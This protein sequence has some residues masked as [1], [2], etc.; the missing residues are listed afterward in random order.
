MDTKSREFSL[1]C[2]IVDFG[3]GSK[4][5]KEAKR[6]GATGGTIFLGKGSVSSHM[7]DLL[8]FSEIRKEVLVI[9][10]SRELEDNLYQGLNK[11]F[12]LEKPHRGIAFSMPLK[13]CFGMRKM[14]GHTRSD[15]QGVNKVEHEAIFTIVDKGLSEQVLDAAKKA[16]A[17]GGTVIHGRGSGTQEKAILFNI[18][19]EPE[20]EI[21]L[22]LA[23]VEDARTIVD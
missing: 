19:I 9:V 14:Q 11:K 3:K 15:K 20:K 18:E 16:G 21:V 22:I 2:L 23:P 13:Y 1:F 12:S 7:L 4:M 5:V 6:L 17:T 10:I 8:G